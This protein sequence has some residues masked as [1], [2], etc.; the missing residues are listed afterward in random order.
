MSL[1]ISFVFG[2]KNTQAH[3]D[4][5]SIVPVESLRAGSTPVP[6]HRLQS[7]VGG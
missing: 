5:L 7:G 1:V 6:E 4:S 2:P 3:G